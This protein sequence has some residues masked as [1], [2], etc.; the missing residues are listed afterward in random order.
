MRLLKITILG[1]LLVFSFGCE[2]GF[3][4]SKSN[5]RD[6]GSVEME[7]NKQNSAS[8]VNKQ[9]IDSNSTAVVKSTDKTKKSNESSFEN[10]NLAKDFRAE[11]QQEAKISTDG[12]WSVSK[13]SIIVALLLSFIFIVLFISLYKK[14]S[15]L[16]NEL[17]T[18]NQKLDEKNW[19]IKELERDLQQ[20]NNRNVDQFQQEKP[21]KVNYEEKRFQDN[22]SKSAHVDEKPYEV[23]LDHKITAPSPSI[24][25]T[26]P[27]TILYAG[28]PSDANTFSAVSSQQDE[29][30]SIFKLI[31]ENKEAISAKFEVIENEYI[32]KM[33]ANS[34]DTYLYHVCKPENSNQ[35]FDG[36]IL[37]TEKG[38]ARLLDGKWKVNDED[39]ATIKFQ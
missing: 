36:R 15:S 17:K 39:K 22:R 16:N 21:V 3:D 6:E 26:K 4:E 14:N 29:H 19:R 2:R 5:S 8:Q 13:Y 25:E 30:R 35:N 11:G 9:E 1:V 32:L 33:A 24:V 20:K 12:T 27:Q 18:K 31:L 23:V 10:Q 7:F 34:P 37:T 38:T 28:K